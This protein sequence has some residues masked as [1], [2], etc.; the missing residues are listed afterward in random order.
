MRI[1]LAAGAAAIVAAAA[2]LTAG[3]DVTAAPAL[4]V[5]D[6]VPGPVWLHLPPASTPILENVGGWRAAPLLV[7]GA[8]AHVDGEF[9]SQDWIYDAHGADTTP[10]PLAPP[11]TSP[12][13][14]AGL[15]TAPTG[16]VAQ[17]TGARHG[18]NAGDL[19][20]IRARAVDGGVAYRFTLN[21]LLHEDT[22][23]VALGIDTDRDATS[24]EAGWGDSIG[25]LGELGLEHAVV[26]SGTTATFGGSP[27]PVRVDED[28]NQIEFVLPLDPGSDIWRHYAVAG[29]SDGDG[30]FASVEEEP[31]ESNPG[32]AHGTDAP[33][34]LNVG[35]RRAEQERMGTEPT[36]T[37]G[38]GAY[39]YG[40]W[41]DHVQAKALAARDI[42]DFHADI[43]F[44][45][46][47]SGRETSNVPT[48][49]FMDRLH[50]SRLALGEGI[51]PAAG[52]GQSDGLLGS[53]QPY[54]L[55][56][57]DDVAAPA[58]FTLL[59]HAAACNYNQY[60]AQAPQLLAQLDAAQGAIVATPMARGQSGGYGGIAE[61]DVFEVWA[62]VASRYA[63]D[64]D[65]VTLTGI[66]MGGIGSFR[67]AS[68]Y[69]DLFTRVFPI[70]G[71]GSDVIDIAENLRNVPLLMWNG[72]PDELVPPTDYLPYQQRLA[73][74]LYR[75]EQDVFPLTDHL[76]H[77]LGSGTDFSRGAAFLGTDPIDRDP[78]RVTYR[79]KRDMADAAID[80]VYDGAYWIDGIVVDLDAPLGTVDAVDL[81]DR[82]EGEPA[83][84]EFTEPGTDPEPYVARGV[85]WTP[86]AATPEDGIR[87]TLT[88]V[89]EVAVDVDRT[90]VE[91]ARPFTVSVEVAG[92]GEAQIDLR[93]LLPGSWIA[94]DGTDVGRAGTAVT[95]PA[96]TH[97]I[98]V[99]PGRA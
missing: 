22:N 31:S 73:E 19:L 49:G 42:S 8:S 5:P 1:R 12:G 68:L 54:A 46:L 83:A 67:L 57:P 82:T 48:S 23:A 9:L 77:P 59:L 50:V 89:V 24:G 10:L 43:D 40:A 93:G 94:L 36:E 21:T 34:V 17:P 75:H 58:P 32:G 45:A 66:S 14:V 53:I 95:V 97:T 44:G 4:G 39:G 56:V 15:A 30:G 37:G 2:S 16:D 91:P 92:V 27:L 98:T 11:D 88:D 71:H 51:E 72:L 69:P 26:V 25:S 20:E 7:S 35:F 18:F 61:V 29:V 65:R 38:R 60:G 28:R 52:P 96:G 74:L 41:R 63:L 3:P 81:A 90:E 70:A 86:T 80:L 85:R 76:V 6:H 47:R 78:R 79:V 84:A 99:R 87:L 55:Y 62:D 13:S 33:P 64:F